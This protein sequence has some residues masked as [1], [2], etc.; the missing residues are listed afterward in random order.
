MP[1]NTTFFAKASQQKI[2]WKDISSDVFKKHTS[3]DAAR[4][5]MAGTSLSTPHESRML[6]EWRK[7]WVFAR[8]GIVGLVFSIAMFIVMEFV[9][10]FAVN[11]LV[12]FFFIAA[13][14]LPLAIVLLL[15]ELNIPR[16][17]P[18]FHV[19]GVFL[20]GGLVNMAAAF[21]I[22]I[23][24]ENQL[25]DQAY[26][27]GPVSEDP[28]KVFA[29]FICLLI[30]K[31]KFNYILNGLLI[32]AAV[33]MG[34]EVFENIGFAVIYN[35]NLPLLIRR[36]ITALGGHIPWAAMMGAGL[37]IAKGKDKLQ[38]KHFVNVHFLKYFAIAY[39]LHT[40]W[41]HPFGEGILVMPYIGGLKDIL[42]MAI[43]W[44]F[45]LRLIK[46]GVTECMQVPQ[47]TPAPQRVQPP[48]LQPVSRPDS[49]GIRTA[50][51]PNVMPQSLRLRGIAGI[52]NGNVF[53]T[54]SGKLVI[55]RDARLANIVYPP[56]TPG[57]SSV[58]CEIKYDNGIFVLIDKNSSNGTFLADGTRLM[59]GQSY[60]IPRKG[61]FYLATCENMFEIE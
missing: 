31:P 59:P 9:G 43:C 41:N 30:I 2:T 54:P 34:F 4:L 37:A 58:H 35:Y 32:G 14:V 20:L 56:N 33:G 40:V 53:P 49:A 26:I 1:G 12:P 39:I 22:R 52:F 27:L 24:F 44:F 10:G 23:V 11:L 5:F 13:I 17:I 16:N 21:F 47:I 15:W 7:P 6:S 46:Q 60:P 42:L 45:L 29:I 36:S 55:G 51:P 8:V 38:A 50:P 19:I 57:I 28:T 3:E 48:P 61:S 25:G 18:I